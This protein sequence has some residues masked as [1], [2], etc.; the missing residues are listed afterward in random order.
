MATSSLVAVAGVAVVGFAVAATGRPDSHVYEYRPISRTAAGIERLI[1][2]GVSIDYGFGDLDLATQPM[3]PAIRFM[4]VR[5]GDRPLAEGSFPRLG[6]YY[7]LYDRPVRW[8]VYLTGSPRPLKHM[9]LAARVRFLGPW[10]PEVFSAWVGRVPAS[11]GS[12]RRAK[13]Q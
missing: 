11:D 5:H 3:E 10:G 1:P 7:E 2:P 8:K 9:R 13:G 6:S 4:L 12:G